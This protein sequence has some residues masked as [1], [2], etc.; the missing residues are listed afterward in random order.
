MICIATPTD[1]VEPTAPGPRVD[2]GRQLLSPTKTAKAIDI[3]RRSLDRLIA[4]GEFPLT[5]LRIGGL[6]RFCADE[7]REWIEEGCPAT[8]ERGQLAR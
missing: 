7:L 6:V 8:W 1:Q 5:K 4:R 3:S 2:D